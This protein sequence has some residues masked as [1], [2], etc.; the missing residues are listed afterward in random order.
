[1]LIQL[2]SWN[3]EDRVASSGLP[4]DARIVSIT[5]LPLER[6]SV[7][8]LESESFDSGGEIDVSF[9][10]RHVNAVPCP[11]VECGGLA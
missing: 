2:I 11:A 7:V 6:V 9:S 3:G 10:I 5:H 8:A 1:M 4:A